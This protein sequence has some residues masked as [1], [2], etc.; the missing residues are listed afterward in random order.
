M[1]KA[2]ETTNN[3][4]REIKAE[5]QSSLALQ[6]QVGLLTKRLEAVEA[7]GLVTARMYADALGQFGGTTSDLPEGP[8][9]FNLLSWL[10]A[11]VQKLP[12]FVGGAVDYGAL[13]G[14]P[15]MR[16]CYLV[17]VVPKVRA[18]KRRNLRGPLTLGRLCP[19]CGNRFRIS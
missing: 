6:Q 10:K 4:H 19:A 7:L 5:K 11:H 17:G 14:P 15:T 2:N 16:R 13:A 18:S 9:A 8:T 1:S 12:S 3:L